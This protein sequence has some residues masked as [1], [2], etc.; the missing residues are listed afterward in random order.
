MKRRLFYLMLCAV[1]ML[2]ALTACIDD[3]IVTRT[4]RATVLLR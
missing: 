4:L 2:S 1:A 3:N